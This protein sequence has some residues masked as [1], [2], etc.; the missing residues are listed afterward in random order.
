[1]GISNRADESL[2]RSHGCK[3]KPVQFRGKVK[4][5]EAKT[6]YF[7]VTMSFPSA[8][9]VTF[10]KSFGNILERDSSPSGYTSGTM[11]ES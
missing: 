8:A 6:S 10:K 7:T 9:P 3:G 5:F 2:S 4:N 11:R 1:M